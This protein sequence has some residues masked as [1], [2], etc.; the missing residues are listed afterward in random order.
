MSA[1][2][3]FVEHALLKMM[4][5]E[6]RPQSF[7]LME[8]W[9][10]RIVSFTTCVEAITITHIL[11]YIET[12]KPGS[13]PW[14]KRNLSSLPRCFVNSD[15]HLPPSCTSLSRNAHTASFTTCRKASASACS[16][17]TLRSR[18]WHKDNCP[19]PFWKHACEGKAAWPK[20]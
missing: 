2:T 15:N 11:R 17:S 12:W 6:L 13:D 18:A 5:M 7:L 20:L 4:D 19:E 16:P 8:D 3:S 9:G 10:S 14:A 1:W